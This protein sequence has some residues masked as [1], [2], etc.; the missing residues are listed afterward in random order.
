MECRI[1][2]AQI[3]ASP[4][5]GQHAYGRAVPEETR[6]ETPGE[7]LPPFG[8]LQTTID[9][10]RMTRVAARIDPGRPFEE[11]TTSAFEERRAQTFAALERRIAQEP[12]VVAVTFADRA[13]GSG[14]ESPRADIEMSPG[15][16]T[17]DDRFGISAVGPSFF[18]AFDRPHRRRACVSPGR[19]ESHGA[20]GHRQ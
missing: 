11:E 16:S 7:C 19:P 14:H 8:R 15:G 4:C 13:P 10:S 3:R 17:F 5:P 18:E 20:N 6:E 12:G 9:A 2:S 1:F